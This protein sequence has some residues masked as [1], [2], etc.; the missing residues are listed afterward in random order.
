M[1]K[2]TGNLFMQKTAKGLEAGTRNV[3]ILDIPYKWKHNNM[4]PVSFFIQHVFKVVACINPSFLFI[5]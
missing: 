2:S 3:S 4:W 5:A 1:N